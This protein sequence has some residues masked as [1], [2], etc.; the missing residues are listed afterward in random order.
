TAEAK[1]AE[2]QAVLKNEG[3]D[4]VV[5]TA[6]PSICW[7]LNIRGSDVAHNPVVLAFAIVPS[8]GKAELFIDPAKIGRDA[9]A[10]LVPLAKL[11]DP[12]T[13]GERLAALRTAG[14]TVRL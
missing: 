5:L 9:K 2:L 4:A 12:R 8:T 3:Q 14:K 13:L 11:R 1:L 10:H 7:L 6:P